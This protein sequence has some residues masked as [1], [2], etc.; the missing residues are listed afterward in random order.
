MT[1]LLV[2][3]RGVEWGAGALVAGTLGGA[4]IE[5]ALQDL[6][7]VGGVH[8]EV[9]D[10]TVVWTWHVPCVAAGP[11]PDDVTY[12][13]RCLALHPMQAGMVLD[14]H[15]DPAVRLEEREIDA[16]PVGDEGDSDR[17]AADDG[18]G[19]PVAD[20]ALYLPTEDTWSTFGLGRIQNNLNL[21]RKAGDLIGPNIIPAILDAGFN[22]DLIDDQTLAEAGRRYK[23]IILPGVRSMPEATSRWLS[24]YA[25][26]GGT[27]IAA[28]RKPER[29]WP[30][31]GS[32]R[33][34]V[35]QLRAVAAAHEPIVH[36]APH[37]GIDD[38]DAVPPSD[39]YP[40]VVPAGV[41]TCQ[42]AGPV[43]AELAIRPGPLLEQGH[44][45]PILARLLAA[46]IHGAVD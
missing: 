34:V 23:A 10:L 11:E 2:G 14:H 15:V 8:T 18:M 36:L 29:A 20:V 33:S 17:H 13:A 40:A 22:F 30:A 21:F 44:Q 9:V 41:R 4:A 39:Y 1:L 24:E 19:E 37:P 46:C 12:E 45:S 27:V 3:F 26:G 7:D 25:K 28:R 5:A 43:T 35:M 38:S 42:G 16:V 31:Y 32:T 6:V